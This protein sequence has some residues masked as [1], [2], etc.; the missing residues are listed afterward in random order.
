M[1]PTLIQCFYDIPLDPEIE[2]VRIRLGIRKNAPIDPD[3]LRMLE[4]GIKQATLPDYTS[5]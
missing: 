2:S 1:A 3:L 5:L 4:Q